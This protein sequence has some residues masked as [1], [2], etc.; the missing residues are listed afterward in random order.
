MIKCRNH[1]RFNLEFCRSLKN[2]PIFFQLN[3]SKMLPRTPV[4]A[5]AVVGI[6][7]VVV[8]SFVVAST[9]GKMVELIGDVVSIELECA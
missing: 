2:V 5:V 9:T 7:A 1:G 4:A 8:F 6:V 3:E